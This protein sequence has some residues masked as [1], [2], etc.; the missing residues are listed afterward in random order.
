MTVLLLVGLTPFAG[1]G[2]LLGHLLTSDSIGP[3]IGGTTAL[4]A[5]LGGAWFPITG[6]HD[7]DDRA[8]RCR[9]TGSCGRARSG[10][11]GAGWGATGWAVVARLERRRRARRRRGRTAA[12]PQR[13]PA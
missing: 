8:R 7:A 13:V 1:L 12:T 6:G 5:L 4:L 10:I 2:I 3:A 11:G 9:R